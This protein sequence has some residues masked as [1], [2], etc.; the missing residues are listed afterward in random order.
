MPMLKRVSLISAALFGVF[1]TSAGAQNKNC[2]TLSG[3]QLVMYSA[4]S[5]TRAFVPLDEI[6][7]CQ[8]GIHGKDF[9]MGS[10]DADRQ[11]TAGGQKADLYAPPDYL[12]IDLLMKPAG[13]SDFNIEFAHGRMVLAY[14]E[15][16]LAAK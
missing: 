16:S 3:E 8:T 4:G 9:P 2:V 1:L 5:L 7:R 12:D 6:F 10:V 11:I 14:S 15:S 13:F